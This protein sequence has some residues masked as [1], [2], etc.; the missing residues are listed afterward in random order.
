[1]VPSIDT[2]LVGKRNF[3]QGVWVQDGMR[4]AEFEFVLEGRGSAIRFDV[5]IIQ[6]ALIRIVRLKWD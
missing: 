4:K 3:G 6:V 5:C 1:M 2:G